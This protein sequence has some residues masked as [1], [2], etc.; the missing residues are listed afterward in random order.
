MRVSVAAE[1]IHKCSGAIWA[2]REGAGAGA[3]HAPWSART[4]AHPNASA[5]SRS[6]RPPRAVRYAATGRPRTVAAVRAIGQ[7]CCTAAA[8]QI[9]NGCV[10]RQSHDAAR[11]LYLPWRARSASAPPIGQAARDKSRRAVNRCLAC[12]AY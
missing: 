2:G 11:R 10:H 12:V 4:A 9:R 3:T 8:P 1:C 7:R 5:L 6:A